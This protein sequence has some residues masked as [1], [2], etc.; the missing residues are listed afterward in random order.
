M[1]PPPIAR[2]DMN[3]IVSGANVMSQLF[4]FYR[5]GI[6]LEIIWFEVVLC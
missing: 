4:N 2:E 3:A 1:S 5:V 6:T